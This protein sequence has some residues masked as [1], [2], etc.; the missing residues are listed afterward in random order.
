MRL[1]NILGLPIKSEE[2]SKEEEKSTTDCELVERTRILDIGEG[3]MKL[4]ELDVNFL[5]GLLCL[6]DLKGH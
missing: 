1:A 5:L 6:G 3:F 2:E 4:F